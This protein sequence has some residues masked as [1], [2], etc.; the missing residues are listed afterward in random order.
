MRLIVGRKKIIRS[1]F[2]AG[3][4]T[5]SW[6]IKALDFERLIGGKDDLSNRQALII[7]MDSIAVQ[8]AD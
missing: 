4:K 2:L 6:A 5:I 7:H 8:E 3:M 1:G